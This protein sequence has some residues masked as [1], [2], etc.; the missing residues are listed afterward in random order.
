MVQSKETVATPFVHLNHFSFYQIA[1]LVK[2]FHIEYT[3]H[4]RRLAVGGLPCVGREPDGIA[5]EIAVVVHVDID[6]FLWDGGTK[7]FQPFHKIQKLAIVFLPFFFSGLFF[8]YD[9][10]QLPFLLGALHNAVHCPQR[11]VIASHINRPQHVF[12][13]LGSSFPFQMVVADVVEYCLTCEVASLDCTGHVHHT[14][15]S[16]GVVVADVEIHIGLSAF[17]A[18]VFLQ[19]H[20]Q[21]FHLPVESQQLM[22]VGVDVEFARDDVHVLQLGCQFDTENF[23]FFGCLCARQA[24]VVHGIEYACIPFLRK[25]PYKTTPEG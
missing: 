14:G 7:P 6:L 23:L 19:V 24:V 17:L 18:H 16:L 8:L 11:T 15:V 12:L 3:A 2:Q 9:L 10:G 20:G 13:H 25:G 22:F 1:F 21:S 5:H 4:Q